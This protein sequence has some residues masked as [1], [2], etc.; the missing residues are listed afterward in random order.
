[1]SLHNPST[2]CDTELDDVRGYWRYKGFVIIIIII[3]SNKVLQRAVTKVTTRATFFW[4]ISSLSKIVT[5]LP[6]QAL[7]AY[8]IIIY[9]N[10]HTIVN[11]YS[12]LYNL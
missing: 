5:L 8:S 6:A 3:I 12:A 4:I 1:M 11:F 10:I 2:R 9:N 7:S